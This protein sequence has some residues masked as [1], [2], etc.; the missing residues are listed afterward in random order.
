MSLY[1]VDFRAQ[2]STLESIG[3]SQLFNTLL[4][5][6]VYKTKEL[7]EAENEKGQQ[8]RQQVEQYKSNSQQYTKYISHYFSYKQD[9]SAQ[10]GR[11]SMSR[12][13]IYKTAGSNVNTSRRVECRADIY[14]SISTNAL[15]SSRTGHK[16]L[17]TII[18]LHNMAT[19]QLII[20]IKTHDL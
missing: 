16:Q 14:L 19:D 6:I 15:F 7:A 1:C 10:A 4:I 5:R 9:Q 8:S 13:Q 17:A 2:P 3:G 20:P 18:I 11:Q 12:P